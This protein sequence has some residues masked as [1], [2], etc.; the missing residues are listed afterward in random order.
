MPVS[1]KR[2]SPF[3]AFEAARRLLP[4]LILMC[5]FPSSASSDM[6]QD[7]RARGLPVGSVLLEDTS[8]VVSM[9]GS[10]AEGD[11]LL[12]RYGGVF[13]ALLDSVGAGWPV[14]GLCVDI[15]GSRLKLLQADLYDAVM[16][17]REGEPDDRVA[18]WVLEHTRVFRA[19]AGAPQAP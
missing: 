11:T 2:V 7:L 1:L 16:Q 4:V 3:R 15:P 14:V 8:L 13:L 18:L 17:I 10:L 9:E 19:E 6:A 5:L 12:K